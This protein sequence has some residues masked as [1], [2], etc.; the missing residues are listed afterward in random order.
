M[1]DRAGQDEGMAIGEFVAGV[2]GETPVD[3]TIDEV[4]STLWVGLVKA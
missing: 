3:R 2:F 4:A 1:A